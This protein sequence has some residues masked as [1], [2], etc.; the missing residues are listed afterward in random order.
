M[1]SRETTIKILQAVLSK[2]EAE[3]DDSASKINRAFERVDSSSE[4]DL[5]NDVARYFEQLTFAKLKIQSIVDEFRLIQEQDKKSFKN[6][7]G[8]NS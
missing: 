7:S 1:A 2:F 8:N 6:G 4:E 5:E 3:R